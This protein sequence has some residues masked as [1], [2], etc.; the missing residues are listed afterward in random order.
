MEQVGGN[1]LPARTSDIRIIILL[2]VVTHTRFLTEFQF[3]SVI[4]FVLAWT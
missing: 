4:I 1:Q 2:K 3:I